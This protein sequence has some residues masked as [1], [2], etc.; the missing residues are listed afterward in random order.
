M[1]DQVGEPEKG[2]YCNR[3]EACRYTKSVQLDNL[4]KATRV[5][6]SWPDPSESR[7]GQLAL[8]LAIFSRFL[9][10]KARLEE[11]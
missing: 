10:A 8:S 2:S 5:T 1:V 6:Y 11:M 4:M 9:Q 3:N 7:C